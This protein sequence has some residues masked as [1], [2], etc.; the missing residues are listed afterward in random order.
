MRIAPVSGT[1]IPSRV[2]V[3]SPRS[4]PATAASVPPVPFVKDSGMVESAT[5]FKLGTVP[6]VAV[7]SG[8]LTVQATVAGVASVAPMPSLI[9]EP[10][11][12]SES[13]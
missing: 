9:P 6:N 3:K 8:V 11:A 12:L 2:S 13:T 1:G 10:L 5:V 7:M 4:T